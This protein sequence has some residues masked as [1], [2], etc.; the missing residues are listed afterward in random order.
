MRTVKTPCHHSS[1]RRFAC[2]CGAMHDW[3]PK[4]RWAE[5]ECGRLHWRGAGGTKRVKGDTICGGVIADAAA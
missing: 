5:C 2:V 3:Q 4:Q 1:N